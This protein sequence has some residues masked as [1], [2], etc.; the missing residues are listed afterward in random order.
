LD[1]LKRHGLDTDRLTT[2][3]ASGVLVGTLYLDSSA[4][5]PLYVNENHS[6]TARSALTAVGVTAS[7]HVAYAEGRATSSS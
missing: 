5:V 6:A 3:V 4:I 1:Y 7:S 2:D